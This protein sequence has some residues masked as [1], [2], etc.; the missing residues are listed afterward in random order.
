MDPGGNIKL[1]R[2]SRMG[3]M[4][5]Q[6]PRVAQV[7]PCG[8]NIG[9]MDRFMLDFMG[10]RASSLNLVLKISKINMAKNKPGENAHWE[11]EGKTMI[12][13][14]AVPP[15]SYFTT[16]RYKPGGRLYKFISCGFDVSGYVCTFF[17]AV[18]RMSSVNESGNRDKTFVMPK[19]TG[20]GKTSKGDALR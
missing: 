14:T 6:V 15:S 7:A 18:S 16:A 8:G 13:L 1:I 12:L 3:V 9:V 5:D 17:P 19:G 2:R 20:L 11:P 4:R 10:I